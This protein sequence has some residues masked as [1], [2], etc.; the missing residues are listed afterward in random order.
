MRKK[1]CLCHG[2]DRRT[3]GFLCCSITSGIAMV[4]VAILLGAE[5]RTGPEERDND[6]KARI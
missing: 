1:L 2:W 6:G 4:Q 5:K 3:R